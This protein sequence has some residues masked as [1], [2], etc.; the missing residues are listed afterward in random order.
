MKQ[1]AGD[2]PSDRRLASTGMATRPR[3]S[4]HW[5]L[6]FLRWLVV[7]L[8]VA[9]YVTSAAVLR[10][11]RLQNLAIREGW[12]RATADQQRLVNVGAP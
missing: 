6:I 10:V 4:Y 9:Q 1:D 2:A 12:Q 5:S 7:A 3:E 8:V 11:H